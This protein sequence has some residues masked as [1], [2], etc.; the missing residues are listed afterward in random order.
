[1]KKVLS[2]LV[3]SLLV[4]PALAFGA[5]SSYGD[6]G[7]CMNHNCEWTDP[8]GPCVDPPGG[9]GGTVT[10]GPPDSLCTEVKHDLSRYVQGCVPGANPST[11]ED[12]QLCCLLDLMETIV[13]YMFV[14]LLV[15]AGLMIIWGAFEFVLSGGDMEK[16][17]NARN[18]LIWALVGVA[19][20][21][22]ARGLVRLVEM[23]LS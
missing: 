21:F 18:K 2:I 5:C 4:F 7:T 8:D 22:A 10:A 1:M 20:A 23:L 14:I 3:L 16:N 11:M 9:S 15:L 19:V 17:K 6:G 13:T 12:G